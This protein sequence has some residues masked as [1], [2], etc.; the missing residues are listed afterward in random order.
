MTEISNSIERESME[1]DVVVVGAGPAGLATA[2]RLMQ[3]AAN[4]QAPLFVRHLREPMVACLRHRF[5]IREGLPLAEI[6]L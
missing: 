3:L 1:V 2:C 5:L 6:L 4:C